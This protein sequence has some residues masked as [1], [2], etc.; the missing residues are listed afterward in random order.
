MYNLPSWLQNALTNKISEYKK[1]IAMFVLKT[2]KN[3]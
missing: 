1:S 2:D 3:S